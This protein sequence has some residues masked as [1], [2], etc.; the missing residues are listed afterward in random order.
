MHFVHLLVN[1]MFEFGIKYMA[2]FGNFWPFRKQ[3]RTLFYIYTG[4]SSIF[5]IIEKQIWN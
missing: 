1:P 5:G 4:F 2:I 3:K